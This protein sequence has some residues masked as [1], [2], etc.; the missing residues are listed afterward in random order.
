MTNEEL[1]IQLQFAGFD[2]AAAR[3]H[4]LNANAQVLALLTDALDAIAI[5][6]SDCNTAALEV[7]KRRLE[8]AVGHIKGQNGGL[9]AEI[10]EEAP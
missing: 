7:A 2:R 4:H 10:R 9:K 8:R 6:E 5:Y 1:R 3:G